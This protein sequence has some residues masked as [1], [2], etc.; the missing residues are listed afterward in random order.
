MIDMSGGSKDDLFQFNKSLLIIGIPKA[1]AGG[2]T[3][4]APPLSEIF[5]E[6]GQPHNNNPQSNHLH[7]L[8]MRVKGFCD[9]HREH[10]AQYRAQY[11]HLKWIQSP[12]PLIT[13]I[14]AAQP[15]GGR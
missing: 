5:R 1:V 14:G 10:H 6:I 13:T 15:Q 7:Q 3:S 12:S 4:L 2:N 11:K 9:D 8:G